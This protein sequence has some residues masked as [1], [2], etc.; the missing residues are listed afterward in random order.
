V[1]SAVQRP[2]KL[3]VLHAGADQVAPVG[4]GQIEMGNDRFPL[5]SGGIN[6]VCHSGNAAF[7]SLT[8]GSATS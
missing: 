6:N 3:D 2:G 7:T 8:S 4:F 1:R 5:I